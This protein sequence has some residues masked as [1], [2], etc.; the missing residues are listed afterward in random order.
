MKSMTC[1]QLGG[2]C[3]QVFYA[4]TFEEMAALSKKHGMEMYQAKDSAHLEAMVE[5]QKIMS[6]PEV[7]KKWMN[8]KIAF[9]N[10][11]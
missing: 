5:M 4:E 8:E 3:D 11:L 9:F 10:A 7:M 6:S 2:A 1:R